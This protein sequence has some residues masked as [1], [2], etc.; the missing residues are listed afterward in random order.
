MTVPRRVSFTT[1]RKGQT[2]R[3]TAARYEA[4][5]ITSKERVGGRR[6]VCSTTQ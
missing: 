1:R 5:V 6:I 3:R 2:R 4:T